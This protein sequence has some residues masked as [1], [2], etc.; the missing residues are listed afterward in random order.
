MIVDRA[1]MQGYKSATTYAKRIGLES[2]SGVAPEDDDGNDAAKAPPVVDKRQPAQK[3]PAA[4]TDQ[5]PR[6]PE[7]IASGIIAAF[8]KA[9]SVDDLDAMVAEGTKAAA[10]WDWLEMESKP[11]AVKVKAAFDARKA[12]LTEIP[13]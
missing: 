3:P 11:H 2:L 5:S 4:A 7:A 8:D 9:Q 10:A 12:K 1:N 6:D 13:Y